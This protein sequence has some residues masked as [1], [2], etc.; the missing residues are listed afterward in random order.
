MITLR[1]PQKICQRNG[2][3]GLDHRR[4]AGDDTR[5]VAAVDGQRLDLAGAD[6]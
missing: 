6:D 5:V 3:G 4:G 2:T 1:L